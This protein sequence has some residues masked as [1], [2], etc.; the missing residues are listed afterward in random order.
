M[1]WK[2]DWRRCKVIDMRTGKTIRKFRTVESAFD[3]ANLFARIT[4]RAIKVVI[5]G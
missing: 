3:Y 2:K 5:E 4:D 1:F